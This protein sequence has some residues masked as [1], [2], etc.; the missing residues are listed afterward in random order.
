V[1]VT[2]RNA[3]QPQNFAKRLL[4]QLG[5][6]AGGKPIVYQDDRQVSMLYVRVDEIPNADP[7]IYFAAQRSAVIRD[8]MRSA[9]DDDDRDDDYY[10][11]QQR[12]IDARLECADDAIADWR[13]DTT[14]VGK[15]LYAM[16]V[17]SKQFGLQDST[18]KTTDHLAR[19][20]VRSYATVPP[21]Y[22]KNFLELTAEALD[23][24]AS[25]PY[26]F[27]L[28]RLPSRP[29]GYRDVQGVA[30]HHRG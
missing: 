30:A 28:G 9:P 4:D 26:A 18:L 12:D 8:E 14:G 3:P 5:S 21:R 27:N 19:S 22:P 10:W 1:A 20:R 29:G 17:R 23:L 2:E 11:D 15:K 7:Q 6:G 24:L 13:D 25:M 16:S